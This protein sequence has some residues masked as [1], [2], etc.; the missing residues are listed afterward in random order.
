MKRRGVLSPEEQV[1]KWK[2]KYWGSSILSLFILFSF[3]YFVI[4]SPRVYDRTE[5]EYI[6]LTLEEINKSEQIIE[7][8]KPKYLKFVKKISIV[9]NIDKAYCRPF[10]FNCM[11]CK[12]GYCGGWYNFFSQ[13]IV[14]EYYDERWAR[15]TVCHEIS[16]SYVYLLPFSH[17]YSHEIV[18]DLA[19]EGVCYESR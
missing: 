6:G 7:E 13:E 8:I 19:E 1:K 17:K 5:I 14:V 18:F 4:L 2:R 15:K 16:H 11:I 9:K 3:I 10:S 12:V